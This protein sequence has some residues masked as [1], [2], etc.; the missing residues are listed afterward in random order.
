[1]IF[2]AIISI[3]N[4]QLPKKSNGISIAKLA[5]NMNILMGHGDYMDTDT[6]IHMAWP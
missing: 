6:D 2:L 1:L 3:E 5:M 4:Y